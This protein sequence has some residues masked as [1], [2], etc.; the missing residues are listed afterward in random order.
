[1]LHK[2]RSSN[3]YHSV[4]VGHNS[5]NNSSN[6]NNNLAESVISTPNQSVG[7]EQNNDCKDGKELNQ[8]TL[9]L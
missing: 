3:F 1:M 5:E 7:G 8:V 9:Y 4:H 2:R 6:G